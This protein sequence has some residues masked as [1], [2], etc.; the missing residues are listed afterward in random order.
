M[1]SSTRETMRSIRGQ[2]VA[3]LLAVAVPLL[4]VTVWSRVEHYRSSVALAHDD[5]LQLAR[6]LASATGELLDVAHRSLDG[7]AQQVE[8]A[9]PAASDADR[10]RRLVEPTSAALPFL[11]DLALLNPEGRVVCST[12]PLPPDTAA[13][14]MDRA[15]FRTAVASDRFVVSAPQR[16]RVRNA[17]VVILAVPVHDRDAV[18]GVLIGSIRLDTFQ[19]LLGAVPLPPNALLTIVD[20]TGTVVARSR[21]F[22]DWAGQKILPSSVQEETVE[23]GVA[24]TRTS[25]VEGDPTTFARVDLPGVG[26]RVFAGLPDAVVYGPGRRQ[27]WRELL[28]ALPLL[29]LALLLP[30]GFYRRVEDALGRLVT[31]VTAAAH[32]AGPNGEGEPGP[33]AAVAA[34]DGEPRRRAAVSEEGPEEV[35]AVARAVNATL[36]ARARAEAAERRA[37]ERYRS[38]LENA[39][40]GIYLSTSDGRIVEANPALAHMM[41]YDSPEALQ[42]VGAEALYP[43]PRVR[44]RIVREHL[45]SGRPIQGLE[46]E[47]RRRDGRPITVRLNGKVIDGGRG[48]PLFELIVE[49]ITEQRAL[50]ERQRQTQKME[51]VGLLA[52]GVAHDINNVLTAILGHATL[53]QHRLSAD[54]DIRSDADEIVVAAQRA[55]ALTRQLLAFSR[56]DVV[57]PRPIDLSA[58]VSELQRMVGRLIGEDVEVVTRLAPDLP[59]VKADPG[60]MEQVVLNLLVN[61]RDALPFGGRIEV[62]TRAEP[63]AGGDERAPRGWVVL[64]VR[65]TGT[66]IPPEVRE[67]IFEPFFTT[68]PPGKGTGLGLST[69]YGIVTQAGGHVDVESAPGQGATFHVWMPAAEEDAMVEKDAPGGEPAGGAR[70]AKAIILLAEDEDA[71]RSVVRRILERA[72]YRVMAAAS[73][74]EALRLAAEHEGPLD[75][76][77]TDVVMPDLGGIETADRLLESR[78]DTPVLFMSGYTESEALRART[79]LEPSLLLSKPFT[80]DAL[81]GRVRDV[82]EAAGD[83]PAGR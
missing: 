81:L 19:D 64:D 43:D 24:L 80:P 13:S 78:P 3:L 73:G 66:G 30:V 62:T 35:R 21:D 51:A 31:G 49:D 46:L 37:K 45:A 63:A 15:W 27:Q 76:L 67:R 2:L 40:F 26:W 5:V 70:D 34:G 9:V 14:A 25:D 59:A 20:S 77:L 82:L 36:E 56:R 6:A 18:A 44:E 53:L 29:L 28:V 4:A 55:S 75:L 10:C 8:A 71:V 17:W 83:A 22:A 79:R 50:E 32:Q 58:L 68:K 23:S 52:G 72:G 47:W 41:G 1:A 7:V 42:A 39:V 33:G 74:A 48:E 60:Q 69:V 11:A 57:Q 65:D 61:A 16:G 54:D 38:V 12:A